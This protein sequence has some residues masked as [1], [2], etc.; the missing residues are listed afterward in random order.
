ML[1]QLI[2]GNVNALVAPEL[3]LVGSETIRRVSIIWQAC[4]DR[5]KLDRALV[6]SFTTSTATAAFYR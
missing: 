1:S 5:I 3:T 2:A 6:R 4:Q